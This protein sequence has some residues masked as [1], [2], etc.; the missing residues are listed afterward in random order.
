MQGAKPEIANAINLSVQA[1]SIQI[2]ATTSNKIGLLRE[3]LID[4][5]QE[6]KSVDG[7]FHVVDFIR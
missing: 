4:F 3:N 5:K 7:G 1:D 2:H 6:D